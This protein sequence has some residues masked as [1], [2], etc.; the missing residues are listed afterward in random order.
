MS[1]EPRLHLGLHK[2]FSSSIWPKNM[3]RPLERQKDP[4]KI[5]SHGPLWTNL[6]MIS[7]QHPLGRISNG[8][9]HKRP[10]IGVLSGIHKF[11]RASC[12]KYF[13]II[14]LALCLAFSSEHFFDNVSDRLSDIPSDNLCDHKTYA[15]FSVWQVFWSSTRFWHHISRINLTFLL[16]YSILCTPS[17]TQILPQ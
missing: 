4:H 3:H 14:Y 17:C 11:H 7:F 9:S 13:L 1:F 2:L 15:R 5:F 16:I 6:I 8:T 10:P 12:L